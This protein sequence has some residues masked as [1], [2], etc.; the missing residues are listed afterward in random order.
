MTLDGGELL[1]E[2]AEDVEDKRT[3]GDGLANIGDVISHKFEVLAVFRDGK[4]A[5]HKSSK[6]DVK[7]KSARFLVPKELGLDG[8]PVVRAVAP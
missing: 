4:I 2:T 3:V 1:V 6:L 7:M 8:E 5:L